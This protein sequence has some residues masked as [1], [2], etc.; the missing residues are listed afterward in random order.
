VRVGIAGDRGADLVNDRIDTRSAPVEDD[1]RPG[2]E[3]VIVWAHAVDANRWST[4]G[5]AKAE[6]LVPCVSLGAGWLDR[7]PGVHREHTA[8]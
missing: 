5:D 6:H 4:I 8:P 3:P 1:L 2:A 7:D